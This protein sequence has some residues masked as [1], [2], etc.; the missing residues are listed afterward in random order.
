MFYFLKKEPKNF[1]TL[2]YVARLTYTSMNKSLLLLFFR[3]EG[4]PSL[5]LRQPHHKP[6]ANHRPILAAPVLSTDPSP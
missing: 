4:L 3:K 2:A 1:F 6:R 5:R